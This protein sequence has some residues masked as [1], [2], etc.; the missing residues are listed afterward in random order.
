MSMFANVIVVIAAMCYSN[1][2]GCSMVVVVYVDRVTVYIGI[3]GGVDVSVGMGVC[4][5]YIVVCCCPLLVLLLSWPMLGLVIV[6]FLLFTC[7]C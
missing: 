1:D 2:V 6:L 3:C 5:Y 4:C 7:R